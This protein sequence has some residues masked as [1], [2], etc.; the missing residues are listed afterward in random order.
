MDLALIETHTQRRDEA[1]REEVEKA[2]FK[3]E[4]W[5]VF[6]HA[7]QQALSQIMDTHFI[8]TPRI[9]DHPGQ[10]IGPRDYARRFRGATV[11]LKFIFTCYKWNNKNT[12]CAD[13][14]HIRVLVT[15]SP[16]TPVTPRYKRKHVLA[17]DPEFT[18]TQPDFKKAQ[19]ESHTEGIIVVDHTAALRLTCLA[20]E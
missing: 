12:F 7:A 14:A 6:T 1:T 18:I 10:L 5:P 11:I 8:L 19:L 2:T 17:Y 15:P 3:I 20:E 16:Y 4:E 13:L 9:Y